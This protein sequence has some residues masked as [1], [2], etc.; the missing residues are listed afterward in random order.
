MASG[1]NARPYP[2]N[3]YAKKELV[4]AQMVECKAQY[5]QKEQKGRG[6]GRKG[7]GKG[8]KGN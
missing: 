5:L 6:R 3:N 2:K 8:K 4:V 7:K 1:K